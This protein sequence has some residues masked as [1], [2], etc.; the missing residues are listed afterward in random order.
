MAKHAILCALAFVAGCGGE[1][2][3]RAPLGGVPAA[4]PRASPLD[5]PASKGS[6]AI[7]VVALTETA[8]VVNGVSISETPTLAELRKAIGDPSRVVELATRIQ[9]YDDLGIALYQRKGDDTY[10]IDM[11]LF[12]ERYSYEFAPATP[13]AGDITIGGEPLDR[14]LD[15]DAVRAWLSATAWVPRDWND[16]YAL[17]W[18]TSSS[19]IFLRGAAIGS[20]TLGWIS[21]SFKGA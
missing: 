20:K 15:R 17:A 1:S 6:A 3:T 4:P 19:V 14:S 2:V 16:D 12:L 18:R 10:V 13:F 21:I 9:V 8:L 5:A 11:S 7:V